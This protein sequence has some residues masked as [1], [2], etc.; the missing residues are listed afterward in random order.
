MDHSKWFNEL[1]LSHLCDC[2]KLLYQHYVYAICLGRFCEAFRHISIKTHVFWVESI[3][4]IYCLLLSL[5]TEDLYVEPDKWLTPQT[6]NHNVVLVSIN[7]VNFN[8][9][10]LLLLLCSRIKRF[11][12]GVATLPTIMI[13]FLFDVESKTFYL[14]PKAKLSIWS[15]DIVMFT[16]ILFSSFRELV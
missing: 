8:R 13:Y 15:N 7:H 1:T 6:P 2:L 4:F 3:L 12:C 5:A 9:A 16:S 10:I 11:S 14:M